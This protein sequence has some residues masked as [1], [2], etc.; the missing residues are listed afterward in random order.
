MAYLVNG[1]AAKSNDERS[2][3]RKISLSIPAP[4]PK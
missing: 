2:N 1:P 3:L 4:A